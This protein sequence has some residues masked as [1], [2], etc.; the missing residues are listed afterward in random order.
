[1]NE[2]LAYKREK[3]ELLPRYS[4][5]CYIGDHFR[6]QLQKDLPCVESS[7]KLMVHSQGQVGG[8][9]AHDPEFSVRKDPIEQI[10][11]SAKFRKTQTD[12]Y[13]KRCKGCGSNHSLNLRFDPRPLAYDALWQVGIFKKRKKLFA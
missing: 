7:L 4:V 8:C 12:L 2:L 9:W 11:R 3:P 10:V 5:I 6:D 13:F 1:L